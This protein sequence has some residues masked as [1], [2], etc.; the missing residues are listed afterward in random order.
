LKPVEKT[1]NVHQYLGR[2]RI[3]R[4]HL[5]TEGKFGQRVG[6]EVENILKTDQ[7]ALLG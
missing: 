3:S 4:P 1:G 6:K 7:I 5:K 2:E